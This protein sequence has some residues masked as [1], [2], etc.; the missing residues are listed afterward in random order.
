MSE[1]HFVGLDVHKNKI[2]YCVKTAAGKIVKEGMVEARRA[3]LSAWAAALPR[4]AVAAMEA[5][6]F[7]GWIYDWL[8]PRIDQ[9]KVAHPLMLKAITASKKKNDKVDA[10][11]IADALR[12]DL[13]PECYM[14][15]SELRQL[16]QVL[17]FRSMMVR[18]AV[19]M[20]NKISGLLME[21][22]IEHEIRR[23]HGKSYFRQLLSGLEKDGQSPPEL[24]LLLS[25]SR[26]HLENFASCERLLLK[27]LAADRRLAERVERLQT[28]PGVGRVTALVWAL[29]V[30]EPGRFAS[31]SRAVSYSGLCS[32]QISS[33]G[34]SRRAPISKQRNAHLQHTLVEAAKLAPGRNAQLRAVHE[35]AL[36]SGCDKNAATLAVARKLVAYLLA[37]DKSGKPFQ[38][39]VAANTSE[40]AAAA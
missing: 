16:R 32:A 3:A 8:R 5:T 33:A 25:L 18:Q 11:K 7:T 10:R 13:L 9:V 31:V 17:R 23:L 15:P 4:P 21:G 1:W 39:R 20:K 29:E 36:A 38:M 24:V 28:I 19:R 26:A 40:A 14:A 34:V 27:R 2:A 12:A 37:V 35:R 30:A 6:I 22:G